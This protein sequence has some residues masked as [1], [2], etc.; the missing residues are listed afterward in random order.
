MR[1][2]ESLTLCDGKGTDAKCEITGTDDAGATV[3]VIS[4][5]KSRGEATICVNLFQSLPKS[6]KMDLIVQKA[7]ELGCVRITPVCSRNCVANIKGKENK[8]CERWQKIVLEAAKQSGRGMIPTV[9]E[10][11]SFSEAVKTAP[12][13]KI[14]FYEGGGHRIDEILGDNPAEIS[15]FI[16]PE[17]GFDL[18]EIELAKNNNVSV[19]TLGP[20][21]LRTET[22]PIAA[23]SI[24]MY[25]TGNME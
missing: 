13:T 24:I 21:I 3:R 8:K 15:L 7:T 12:G 6:D 11:M 1:I 20:R 18:S 19:A 17:G 4:K 10:A 22:A 5:A 2:G 14:I 16:G 25:A 23:L 9:E